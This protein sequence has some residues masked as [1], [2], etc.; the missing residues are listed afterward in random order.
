L[1]INLNAC[2]R[3]EDQLVRQA[4]AVEISQ[5]QFVKAMHDQRDEVP[6]YAE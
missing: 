2:E 4:N 5:K 3:A 1:P 6:A